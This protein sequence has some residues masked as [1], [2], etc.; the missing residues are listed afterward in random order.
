[1]DTWNEVEDF[2]VGA[3]VSVEGVNGRA[4]GRVSAKDEANQTLTVGG[5]VVKFGVAPSVEPDAPEQTHGG[6]EK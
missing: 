5:K 6:V 1:M 4:H 3:D 2:E